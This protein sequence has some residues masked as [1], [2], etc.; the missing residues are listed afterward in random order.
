[1]LVQSTLKNELLL[2]LP[3]AGQSTQSSQTLAAKLFRR[4]GGSSAQWDRPLVQDRAADGMT[5]EIVLAARAPE[6]GVGFH[7][8]RHPSTIS[9]ED[10]DTSIETANMSVCATCLMKICDRLQ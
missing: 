1:M 3:L 9:Q 8:R 10:L 7:E 4:F 5:T 2:T 6:N